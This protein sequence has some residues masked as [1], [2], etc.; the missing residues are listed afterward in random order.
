MR[1]KKAAFDQISGLSIGLVTIGVILVVGLL[2]LANMK[3]QIA[4][5]L[6]S[7]TSINES[8]T[9]TNNTL[10]QLAYRNVYSLSCNTVYNGTN[11]VVI[12]AG[13]YT[14]STTGITIINQTD[15][16]FKSPALVTYTFQPFDEGYNATSSV[17][18]SVNTVP[19]WLTI[20]VIV[21]IGSILIGLVLAF[22]KRQE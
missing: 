3:T 22:R 10:A 11:G 4:G 12:G 6:P 17:Q 19:G 1:Y 5:Q 7:R 16:S 21:I 15:V 18:T 2:V 20:V 14:C 8:V 13:N 9:W